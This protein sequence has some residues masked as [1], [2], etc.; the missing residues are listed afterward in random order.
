MNNG[1]TGAAYCYGVTNDNAAKVIKNCI[2]TDPSG[3]T[4]GTIACFQ[5]TASATVA[6]NL[7]SDTS[8]T[9]TGSLTSKS[10]ANQ[11]V[12]TTGGSE[13]LHLVT[14]ADAKNAGTDLG[15][16]PSGVE[17]DI[18]GLDINADA[19]NDPWDMGAD[20]FVAAPPAAARIWEIGT[21]TTDGG[22]AGRIWEIGP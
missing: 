1:G 13:N 3:T 17:V 15:T 20:E 10:S 16:S 9:G 4:S 6:Y 7:S 14:G 8:A 22:A 12:S 11:F 5:S 2:G 18:D 19:S 21:L